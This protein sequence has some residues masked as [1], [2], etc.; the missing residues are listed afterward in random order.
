M[1]FLLGRG[2]FTNKGLEVQANFHSRE[3][4]IR[5]FLGQTLLINVK[6]LF[7]MLVTH[8]R[9]APGLISPNIRLS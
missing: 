7:M 4:M 5:H 3:Y 8:R 9:S 2:C 6:V 1:T